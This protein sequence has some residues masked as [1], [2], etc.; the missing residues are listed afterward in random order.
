M[1]LLALALLLV[2]AFMHATWNLLAKRVAG[3]PTFVWLFGSLSALLYAPLVALVIL[4]ERPRLGPIDFA[5]MAGSAVLHLSYF[6]ILQR[7][8]QVGDLSLVYPLARGT[9]PTLATVGAIFILGEHPGPIAL[10]GTALVVIAVFLITGGFSALRRGTAS[11]RP[12]IGY[13]LLTGCFIATYSLWDKHAVSAL[14]IS[15]L[16]L[17]WSTSLF[18]SIVLAPVARRRWCEVRALW[19]TYRR[20]T[21]GVALLSPLAYLLVLTALSFTPV[22]RIAPAREISILVGTFFGTRMLTE[23]Q[24]RRRLASATIMVA[25]VIALTFG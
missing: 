6:L 15:P 13:G 2:A 8:Y 10:C 18:R 16:L 5:F 25:G 21:L 20:E 4:I 9:G 22:S 3:G 23:G 7:G 24:S 17:D 19:A 12:A 14:A 11:V 1:T